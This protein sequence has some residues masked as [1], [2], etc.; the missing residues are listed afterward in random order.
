MT[1]GSANKFNILRQS[2]YDLQPAKESGR[3]ETANP[4]PQAEEWVPSRYNIRST[5]E[6]GGLILWNTLNGSIS[7]FKPE[8]V[9]AVKSMLGHK[10]TKHRTNGAFKYFCQRGFLVKKKT[11]EYKQFQF[12]FGTRHYRPDV[13]E[14][15]LLASEDCNFRCQYCYE[16]F[17]RGS[18]KPWVREAI[19]NHVR[20]RVEENSLRYLVIGWFGGE[21]LY[22]LQA[23]EDLAP[24]FAETCK[25][26]DIFFQSHITTNGYLLSPDVAK[27]L[28]SWKINR[29]QITVDGLPEDHDRNRPTREGGSTFHEILKNLRSMANR[30]DDFIVEIRINYDRQSYPRMEGL[31]DL[32]GEEFGGDARF[33]LRLRPVGRWGGSNDENLD[34]CG[35]DEGIKGRNILTDE[36]RKRGLDSCDN[37]SRLNGPGAQVC[38][39]ARP[40]HFIVGAHGKIMKCTVAL[41]KKDYNILGNITEEG[42]LDID[43]EKL[44]LWTEPAFENDAQCRKCVI[45]PVCQGIACPLGRIERDERPCPPVRKNAKKDLLA[46]HR[47]K[48][49]DSS[50]LA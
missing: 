45:L 19:K 49:A 21:P 17:K 4:L 20:K 12:T 3:L 23:I 37:I 43:H 7:A 46:A 48:T 5:T 38:Y 11:D 26:H 33:R 39:A 40:Y 8:H 24:F 10:G 14:L 35:I 25:E 9:E 15:T 29:F 44:G 34:I 28:L 32:L 18:M 41:D 22:G 31:L 27:K 42:T 36:A 6:N 1:L 13:L 16:D 50:A 2:P 30:Q 47:F